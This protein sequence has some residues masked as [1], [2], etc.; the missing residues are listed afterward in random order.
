MCGIA[1]IQS[2]CPRS[3]APVIVAMTEALSHRGPDDWGYLAASPGVRSPGLRSKR[4]PESSGTV[5]LGHRRLS[6]IDV[7]GSRQPLCNEDGSVWT[8]FNGE[9]YNYRELAG[10]LAAKGHTLRDKGDTETLVHLWEDMGERMVERLVGMFAF[11]IYDANKDLL[12][13]ARDRF[14]QKPVYYH[15]KGGL[16]AFA[17]E[18]Q[19]FRG[20]KE[21]DH[22]DIDPV[23]MA[24]YFK[25]GY[26]PSPR[27]VYNSVKCLPAGTTLSRRNG[28]S[29][30]SLYWKPSVVGTGDSVDLGELQS[31]L[32]ES[33][34]MQL[35]SD[36]PLGT[37][38]SGGVDS[39]LITASMV[40]QL[41]G[42]V[43]SFTIST[44]K[45]W[46][47]E[48]DEA[49]STA[50][51]LGTEHH[52]IRVCPDFTDLTGKL[53]GH[54]GQ[55]FADP[56]SILTYCVSRESRRFVKVALSGDGGD[57][58]F[59]G[60]GGYVNSKLYAT[61]ARIPRWAKI[62]IARALTMAPFKSRRLQ[63]LPDKILAAACP[64]VKGENVASLFHDYWRSTGFE[65]SFMKDLSVHREEELDVFTRYYKEAP[66][67][68][69]IEKW[70]E[71]DQRMYLA[72]D[73]LVKVDV[74]SMAASLECRAPFLDHRLAEKVNALPIKEKL[75]GNTTKYLLRKLAERRVPE[76]IAW[77]PKK[78]FSMPLGDWM[79]GALKDWTYSLLFD[80]TSA[81]R[82][83]LRPQV[84]DRLWREHQAGRID[85]QVRLW[86]I[87]SLSLW[88]ESLAQDTERSHQCMSQ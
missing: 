1:G 39:A 26:I 85:H 18:L 70:L 76:S 28:L 86:L 36:V 9:I 13:L 83:Y 61:A 52:E 64:P 19:A 33:V 35:R 48:S 50:E 3:L 44:G 30:V 5:F 25:Y 79:R 8:V 24:A 54:Y 58:I 45:N 78:G 57:E 32:D 65:T 46:Y 75:M 20:L 4:P 80:D 87:A 34:R 88:R 73:I 53:A 66:S 43:K 60:Y 82:P 22:D 23:A 29:R 62:S 12:F 14:G 10:E 69:A 38:L 2:D 67:D 21:L 6:I 72:D 40:H 27:T 37:F 31:A 55:P 81:W 41:G 7:D 47:D 17:S 56:S 15:E 68:D 63:L 16:F 59:G 71:T 74:A 51:H 49:R 42:G 11:A 77:L 84:V